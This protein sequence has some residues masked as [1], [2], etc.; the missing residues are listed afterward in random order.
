MND[1]AQDSVYKLGPSILAALRRQLP[2][3][4]RDIGLRPGTFGPRAAL[5]GA[6][7]AGA[8][9]AEWRRTR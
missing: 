8:A 4:L 1:T 6:A 3:H 5:V 9:G 7:L 2:A